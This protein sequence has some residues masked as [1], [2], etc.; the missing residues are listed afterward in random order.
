MIIKLVNQK[1]KIK[2]LLNIFKIFEYCINI[3]KD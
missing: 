1:L 3:T 2:L